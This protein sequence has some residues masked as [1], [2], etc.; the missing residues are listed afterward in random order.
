MA[1]LRIKKVGD[2]YRFYARWRDGTKDVE[3]PVGAAWVVP[4]GHADAKPGGAVCGSYIDRKGRKAPEG[5]LSIDGAKGELP[6]VEQAWKDEQAER[7]ADLMP[8]QI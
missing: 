5:F 2:G 1:T 4:A 6:N 8:E 7:H 3:R